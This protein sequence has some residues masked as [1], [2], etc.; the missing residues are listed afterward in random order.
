MGPTL[1]PKN[2]NLIAKA[3]KALVL[4][5]PSGYRLVGVGAL[6]PLGQEAVSLKFEFRQILNDWSK[7]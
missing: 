2:N 1:K 7:N 6:E 4:G 3:E 5:Q